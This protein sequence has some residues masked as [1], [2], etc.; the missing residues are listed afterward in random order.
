MR[1]WLSRLFPL[2]ALEDVGARGAHVRV[3]LVVT[4]PDVLSSPIAPTR[5]AAI[6]WTVLESISVG[7]RGGG[8]SQLLRPLASGW[9]GG[10][11]LGRSE[12]GA[13]VEIDL[14]GA[15]FSSPYVDPQ[16]GVTIQSGP[17]AVVYAEAIA[18]VGPR[19]GLL[20]LREAPIVSGQRIGLRAFVVRT[21]RTAAGYRDAPTESG[22]ELH[23]SR[24]VT[25]VE[26]LS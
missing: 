21:A 25:I 7:Q 3:E 8:S 9:R 16:D 2:R 18:R 13:V 17:A 26:R 6:R 15:R 14:S 5:S 23:A 4:S 20:Y 19:T 24:S 10:P 22:A 11:L 12:T 1:S